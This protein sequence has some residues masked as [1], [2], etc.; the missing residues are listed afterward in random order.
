MNDIYNSDFPFHTQRN[1]HIPKWIWVI[2]IAAILIGAI[3]GYYIGNAATI[4]VK[5]M[6]ITDQNGEN[7]DLAVLDFTDFLFV[8][9]NE[10]GYNRF[11]SNY[12]SSFYDCTRPYDNSNSTYFNE[13]KD[14]CDFTVSFGMF[15]YYEIACVLETESQAFNYSFKSNISGGNFEAR[16]YK[17]DK[18]YRVSETDYGE[19]IIDSEYLTLLEE[20]HANTEYNGS[21]SVSSEYYYI[22]VTGA[23]SAFG[24]YDFNITSQK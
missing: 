24:S 5:D 15:N 7:T 9:D 20:F 23:E 13:F 16:I 3:F 12:I 2:G 18:N 21:I 19:L 10:Y 11:D 17:L 22:L 14:N 6:I 4:L 1:P 8:Y